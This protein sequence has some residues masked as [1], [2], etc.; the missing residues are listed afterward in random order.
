[1]IPIKDL[2]VG[3]WALKPCIKPSNF[4]YIDE[5]AHQFVMKCDKKKV[6]KYT[7]LPF[8]NV[9]FTEYAK[10]HPELS[11]KTEQY[12]YSHEFEKTFDYTGP[13]PLEEL[14][15]ASAI[16]A[17]C[18]SENL[19]VIPPLYRDEEFVD[20]LKKKNKEFIE[21]E[22]SNRAAR[23][24][25]R[26][27]NILMLYIDTISRPNLFRSLPKTIKFLEDF[28]KKSESPN[29]PATISQF[30]RIHAYVHHTEPNSRGM[31]TGTQNMSSLPFIWEDLKRA[32]YATFIADNS[33]VEW[34]RKYGGRSSQPDFSPNSVW[35]HKDYTRDP[36]TD[37]NLLKGPN[38]V[39]TRCISGL[40]T[41]E[42]MFGFAETFDKQYA[43][44]PRFSLLKFTEG[45]EV[46][47]RVVTLIDDNLTY[48]LENVD[49][50][51]TVVFLLSDHGNHMGYLSF[52]S[53]LYSFHLESILPGL[54]IMAPK[55]ITQSPL[56]NNHLE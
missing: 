20:I 7:I 23:S 38:S 15:D 55:W 4:A 56:T 6:A 43:D 11:I 49:Y 29:F 32:G 18:G 31:F 27:P 13:V 44:V 40:R 53:A 22:N 54:F 10:S 34:A 35:C 30:L 1:M 45:H 42:L 19:I 51:N 12:V 39:K 5:N 46:T 50:N 48:Y 21:S 2:F 26:T 3:S 8:V 52:I 9:N 17:H 36:D 14:R 24:A 47:T 16:D 37:Y 33:C 28:A 25:G 41:D